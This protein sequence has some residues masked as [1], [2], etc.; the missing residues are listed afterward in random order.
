MTRMEGGGEGEGQGQGQGQGEVVTVSVLERHPFTTQT[1]I[2]LGLAPGDAA[3][4]LVV[5]A[6]ALRP[7]PSPTSHPSVASD[8]ERPQD[9]DRGEMP[10]V[11]RLR[12]FVAHGGQAVTYG[13]G[14]W[15]AP[16]VV[17]GWRR[18]DFVVVQACN[19]VGG[20]ECEEWG[21]GDGDGVEVW[22]GAE[23][24]GGVVWDLVSDMATS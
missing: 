8:P 18:L 11:A 22:V 1:F 2:P 9:Y 5:V 19:G 21:M 14:T 17:V 20:E 3:R 10:D 6:P 24:G 15:H 13:E 16:M 12:A 7:P 4:Y 23:G